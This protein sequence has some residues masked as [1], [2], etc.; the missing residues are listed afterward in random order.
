MRN[1]PH[2]ATAQLRLESVLHSLS[3]STR[4]QV[5]RSLAREGEQSCSAFHDLGDVS[6]PTLSHHLRVLREGGVTRTRLAGRQRFV[7]LRRDD[8][9]ARF[10]G[11]L[12]SILANATPRVTTG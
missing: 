11:L 3:D 7:S 2:P 12:D 8:L 9:D 10:P 1:P 6:L 4:L 5:V